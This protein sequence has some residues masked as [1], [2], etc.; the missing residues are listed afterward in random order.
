MSKKFIILTAAASIVS[1]G[2]AFG[3]GWFRQSQI[4]QA[5]PQAQAASAQPS[6]AEVG[7]ATPTATAA[8]TKSE[9][10]AT[11]AMTKT[12]LKG[13]VAEV[14][15]RVTEYEK[16]IKNLESDEQRLQMAHEIVTKDIEKLNY[17]RVELAAAVTGLKSQ[18]D[19][20]EKTL[21]QISEVE[22]RNFAAIAATYDKMQADSAGKI[23]ANMAKMSSGTASGFDDAVKIL[24][25]MTE[26]TR[27]KLLS[28]L[29]VSEP[30]L[31]ALFCQKLKRVVEIQ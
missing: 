11:R 30:N 25:Y 26:R 22:K 29:A 10:E 12:Q 14:R 31:A 20:L 8:D 1:F 7:Q 3:F 24:Y 21:V 17:L 9:E 4:K 23:L 18:R 15:D 5:P 16:K 13:L 19:E 28:E 2:A 6:L 27:G